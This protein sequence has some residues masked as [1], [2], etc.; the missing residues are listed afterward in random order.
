MR[1][2]EWIS[3]NQDK[4]FASIAELIQIPSVLGAPGSGAPFGAE[5][6][7]CLDRALQLAENMGLR[8]GRMGGW[9]GWCE[10]GCGEKMVA[11]LAHLDVV[12][13][14]DGWTVPAYAGTLQDGRLYGRGALDDKGPAV[15]AMYALAALKEGGVQLP[16]RVRILFGTNEESGSAC[17]RY[18]VEHGGEI[19]TYGFTPDSSY[20]VVNGEKGII[21]LEF[22]A[23]LIQTGG[24][25]IRKIQA[26]IAPNSV[27]AGGDAVLEV[28]DDQTG[29]ML[30]QQGYAPRN[31]V[32][33][34]HCEGRAAHAST[35]W[36][37]E[38][39]AGKLLRLL[40]RLLPAAADG[41]LGFLAEKM[42]KEWDGTSLGIACEDVPSGKLTCNLGVLTADM[43]SVTVKLNL[44]CPVTVDGDRI[45]KQVQDMFQDAGFE[46]VHSAHRRGFYLPKTHPLIC[47]LSEIYT[48]HTGEQSEARC[49]GGGTYAKAMPNVVAFG[50]NFPGDE[51][52]E[53]QADEYVCCDR[54]LQNAAIF[55]DAMQ[56]LACLAVHEGAV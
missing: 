34:L 46:C 30:A 6:G 48:R 45:M 47:T 3:A 21:N 19:P 12:P 27:P 25:M 39:A 28:V 50:P 55:L 33:K 52:R 4:L 20:P 29:E 51:A 9:A 15:T 23:P 5:V 53:H 18:Y 38:N 7:R 49:I 31:N 10:W 17:M 32:V 56:E 40:C 54:L 36:E 8:T 11:V 35:P 37:G 16:C 41:P 22:C 42:G 44:R 14:G 26:G 2:E 43:S 24:V 13:A 1:P